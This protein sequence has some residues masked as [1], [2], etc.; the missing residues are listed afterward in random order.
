MTATTE[1]AAPVIGAL[2]A[3]LDRISDADRAARLEQ[4]GAAW[5]ARLERN[6]A[7]G[8]ITA[9]AEGVAAGAVATAISAGRHRLVIDEP[10]ALAGDDLGPSPV[11]YLLAALIGC[12][13]VVYRLYAQQLGLRVDALE[14]DAQ[15]QLD[16]RGL[17]GVDPSVR[18]GFQ[19]IRLTV[20]ITG[21]E[22]RE[23]YEELQRLVDA[24]CPVGDTL[25]RG[26]TVVTTLD[27]AGVAESAA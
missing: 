6:P 19:D 18:S 26:T 22:P 23:R 15:G 2:E 14:F 4:A 13:T 5:A 8:R 9:R 1:T 3:E 27:V 12:Q 16:V 17:F 7:A 24:H 25:E 21:P 20:R 10:A 11:E